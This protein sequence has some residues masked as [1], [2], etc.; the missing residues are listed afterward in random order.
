MVPVTLVE[1]VSGMTCHSCEQV[2]E[3]EL[4]ALPGVVTVS[5]NS[6]RGRVTLTTTGDIDRD[7]IAAAL[8]AHSYRLGER[9][10]WLTRE[11]AVWRD[12]T[13]AIVGLTLVIGTLW[14]LGLETALSSLVA[15]PSVGLIV[16]LT[17]GLAAGVSTCMATVGG[18]VLA[19]AAHHDAQVPRPS[20]RSTIAMH[21][22][23]NV[24]RIV[25]FVVFGAA[26][27]AVGSLF[28]LSGVGLAVAMIAA[29]L[30][31][32]VIGIRLSGM[33]PRVAAMS[34][35]LPG[36]LSARFQSRQSTAGGSNSSSNTRA[37]LLGLASFF[38]P[39][40]FTQA[41]QVYALSTGDPVQAGLIMGAFA[42]GTAPALASLA[43]VPLLASGHRR[44]R[45]LRFAGVAVLAFAAVNVAT[46][47]NPIGVASSTPQA[48][49]AAVTD[50]VVI[51]DGV[52]VMSMT[53]DGY[54]YLPQHSVVYA[55][56]PV[57]W[58]IEGNGVTCASA[59]L[60][61]ELGIPTATI[62]W[63]GETSTFSFTI[64]EPGRVEFAC[65][66]LMFFGSVTAIEPP[67]AAEATTVPTA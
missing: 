32:T 1:H 28:S 37:G 61:P 38:I 40:G 11:R 23:F 5:A 36:W 6:R 48:A 34:P 29:A 19:V 2:I 45:L 54:N 8:E 56:L 57:T 63:P 12:V 18:L 44:E 26:T 13:I 65:S 10:A 16:P 47:L 22:W 66:M 39:C 60:A 42:L 43:G 53:I 46:V 52:Q 3:R 21:A 30:V 41:M 58:E 33:S 50:N 14:A 24:S 7:A 25:G 51:V 64:E 55:G 4:G 15:S 9:A 59:L 67:A 62:V 17:V 49:P 31:M 27:G 35:Q 20:R